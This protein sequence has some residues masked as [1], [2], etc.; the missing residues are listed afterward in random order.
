M[1][2]F[3]DRLRVQNKLIRL[4]ELELEAAKYDIDMVYIQFIEA[5]LTKAKKTRDTILFG[6]FK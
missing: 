3:K 6:K 4:Y 5:K 1:L 2:N